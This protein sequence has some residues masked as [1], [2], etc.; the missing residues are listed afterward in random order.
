M[1]ILV[2]GSNGQV[3]HEFTLLAPQSQH[4]IVCF[5]RHGL[6]ITDAAKVKE[7]I[8]NEQP[9]VVINCAAY[10]AV[11]KAESEPDTAFTINASG[12]ENLASACREVNAVLIHISTDYVFAGD[13]LSPYNESDPTGPSGVYGESKLAGEIAIAQQLEQHIIL[14]TAWVFGA[15][16]NNF[17]KT[18]LRLG[19]ERDELGV[20]NDQ[21]GA[22]TSAKGIADCCLTIANTIAQRN[23]QDIAWGIYHYS[24]APYTEWFGFAEH[25]FDAAV[26]L[27]LL[28]NAPKLN[29]IS[30][31]QFPT[32]AKRPANSRLSCDKL[33]S[34]FEI[35]PDDW[36]YHLEQVLL[37]VR[38]K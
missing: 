34:N 12:A 17:V 10:T 36:K 7:V 23:K 1:K 26:R 16:G 18:M 35:V 29:P 14:R 30:S 3:G 8:H 22:P 5:D 6:D 27:N 19:A 4:N 33:A 2:T 21:L 28:N 32:P 25:I 38:E 24:G 15:H 31:D 20:V 37:T 11:D 13:T 9:Q